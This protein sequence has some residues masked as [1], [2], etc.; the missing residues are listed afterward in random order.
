MQG[1]PKSGAQ[2][3]SVAEAE[4]IAITSEDEFGRWL[5]AALEWERQRIETVE[6][7]NSSASGGH[8]Q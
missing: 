4:R 3:D 6:S 7:A 5:I 2:W 1:I 8:Q